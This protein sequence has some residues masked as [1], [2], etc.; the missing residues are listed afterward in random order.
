MSLKEWFV[1]SFLT[2]RIHKGVFASGS[3]VWGYSSSTFFSVPQRQS[4]WNTRITHSS[5]RRC[6][7]DIC[8]VKSC[9]SE[10]HLRWHGDDFSASCAQTFD[11]SFTFEI[12]LNERSLWSSAL[13]PP[14][15]SALVF[16]V[17]FIC[18]RVFA[19]CWCAE[20]STDLPV[21]GKKLF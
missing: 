2:R 9:L 14:L 16:Q 19:A 7:Y 4:S 8:T 1:L 10:R 5:P 13:T 21:R 15:V 11:F 17:S 12:L 3:P 18:V 20:I 6:V